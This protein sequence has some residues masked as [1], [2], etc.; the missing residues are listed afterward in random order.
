MKT[1]M[2]PAALQDVALPQ[3]L[4]GKLTANRIRDVNLSDL[5]SGPD[6]VGERGWRGKIASSDRLM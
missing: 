3:S 5:L 6:L 2:L 4:I 1:F